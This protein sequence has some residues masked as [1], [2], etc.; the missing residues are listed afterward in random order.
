MIKLCE[1]LK[2]QHI[3][4][5]LQ[6]EIRCLSTGRVLNMLCELRGEPQDY[7]Q[8]SSRLDF[9][10][11]FENE[12]QLEKLAYLVDIFSSC[13]PLEQVSVRCWRTSFGSK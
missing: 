9:A 1:D 3:N 4:I 8:E 10:K 12:E 6:T 7:F 2:K 5:M 11:C 13:E